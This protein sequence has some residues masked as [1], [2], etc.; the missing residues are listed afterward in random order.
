MNQIFSYLKEQ[1][2]RPKTIPLMGTGIVILVISSIVGISDNLP[3]IAL[4]FVGLS[5]LFYAFVHHWQEARQF[6]TLL[7][8]AV[9]SFPVL[10]LLHNIFDGVNSQIGIIPVLNQ[11]L[12]GLAVISF[13]GRRALTAQESQKRLEKLK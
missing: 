5:I 4:A 9:I 13:H 1:F 12:T 10:A 6:G 8:V 3:G 2:K 7:A 11:L